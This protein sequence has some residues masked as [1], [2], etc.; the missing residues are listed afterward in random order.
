MSRL[1]VRLSLLSLVVA[2][3]AVIVDRLLAAWKAGEGPRPIHMLEVIDAPVDEVWRVLTDIPLQ[4]EWMHEMKEVSVTP[5]GPVRVG[6]RGEAL[7]RIFGI[8]VRDTV[9]VTVVDA[10]HT[11][12]I[13]HDGLFRGGGVITLERGADGTTTVVRWAETLVPPLLPHLGALLQ[14]PILERIFQGDLRSLK[15]LVETGSAD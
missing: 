14:A 15:A 11:Y 7:V 8:S 6:T 5:P 3:K 1:L 4:V 9:E 12:A 13:R 10:P 2:V